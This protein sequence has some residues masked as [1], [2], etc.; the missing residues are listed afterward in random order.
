MASRPSTKVSK[1]QLERYFSEARSWETDKVLAIEKSR[2]TAWL[3]ASISGL[4]TFMAVMAVG[5]LAPLKSVQPYVVRVDNAT[6]AVDIVSALTGAPAKYDE[7]VNKYFL[8]NYVRW[9]EG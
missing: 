9:R 5:M 2:K 8:Q 6:G 7:A 1:D 4:I 3:I